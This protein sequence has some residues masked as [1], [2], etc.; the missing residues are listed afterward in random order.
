M[1][2]NTE[3]DKKNRLTAVAFQMLLSSLA[4]DREAAAD[5]YLRLRIRL[6]RYFEVRG[7]AFADD[8]AD[9]VLDRLARKLTDGSAIEVPGT[10][11]LGIARML[12]LE[13]RKSAISRTINDLPDVPVSDQDPTHAQEKEKRLACLDRCLEELT[14]EN[15]ELIV[16]YY[17]SE[18]RTKIEN[19]QLL[20]DKLG[21][22]NNA[23]RNRAVRLRGKLESCIGSCLKG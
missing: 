17:E 13:L 1:G 11:A 6:I 5:E 23:L 21:V 7:F 8:A 4:E 22:S 2:R 16:R 14:G 19:R 12:T 20:A 15:R 18:K 3:P 10:Y 9:E